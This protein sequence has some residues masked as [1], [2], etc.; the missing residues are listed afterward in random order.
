MRRLEDV[1]RRVNS[2]P[3]F[4][5]ALKKPLD[6]YMKLHQK[7]EKGTSLDFNSGALIFIISASNRNSA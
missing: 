5:Q 3:F 1:Y 7:C 4:R 6:L 2:K